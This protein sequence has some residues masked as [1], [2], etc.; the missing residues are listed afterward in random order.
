M[1]SLQNNFFLWTGILF[2]VTVFTLLFGYVL[3]RAF[4]WVP[5]SHQA[6]ALQAAQREYQRVASLPSQ[7]DYGD[8]DVASQV[9]GPK[10]ESP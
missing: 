2:W 6:R 3:W 5:W 1:N 9:L 4:R 8:D 7:E 10:S